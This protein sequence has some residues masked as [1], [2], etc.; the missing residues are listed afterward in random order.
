MFLLTL[1][2]LWHTDPVMCALD[3]LS[4]VLSQSKCFIAVL[5]LGITALISLVGSVVASTTALVQQV[6]TAYHVNSLSKKMC[7]WPCLLRNI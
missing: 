1:T 5:I 7:L 3:Q 4:S 6:H 2:Q